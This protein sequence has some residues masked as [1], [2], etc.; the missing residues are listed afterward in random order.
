[1]DR[2]WRIRS[3]RREDANLRRGK[4]SVCKTSHELEWGLKHK[5]GLELLCGPDKTG[6]CDRQPHEVLCSHGKHRFPQLAKCEMTQQFSAF[7][8]THLQI[9]RHLP[10]FCLLS[11]KQ[12]FLN[13]KW[14][15]QGWM[16]GRCRITSVTGAAQTCT[17]NR[18]F[19]LAVP[20]PSKFPRRF[21]R[22]HSWVDEQL[23]V[24]HVCPSATWHK[25]NKVLCFFSSSSFFSLKDL[26]MREFSQPW[27]SCSTRV[28]KPRR[29]TSGCQTSVAK[30]DL[31][32]ISLSIFMT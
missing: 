10:S 21:F 24:I 1:M 26:L 31:P 5:Q 16:F 7:Y 6:S 25:E 4:K 14:A 17:L 27:A 22:G 18:C 3:K 28:S 11:C 9:Q 2:V 15:Q 23:S 8:A 13:V 19:A 32:R 29:N 12:V 20:P 30:H